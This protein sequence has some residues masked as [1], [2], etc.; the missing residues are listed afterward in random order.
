MACVLI[1]DDNESS[2]RVLQ[3]LL[4]EAGH[5]VQ[6]AANGFCRGPG[7]RHS[8]DRKVKAAPSARASP[9]PRIAHARARYSRC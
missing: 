2:R 1:V 8:G 5:A 9:P 6:E 4:S 3:A 7:G